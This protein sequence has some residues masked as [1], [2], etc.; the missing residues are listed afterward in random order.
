MS[1]SITPLASASTSW[2]SV[3]D[4]VTA[5]GYRAHKEH[6]LFLQAL[7]IYR[8]CP[9]CLAFLTAAREGMGQGNRE[10]LQ[11]YRMQTGSTWRGQVC[12]SL[13]QTLRDVKEPPDIT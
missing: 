9:M 7:N 6:L 4:N 1:E 2:V 10:P 3:T 8:V 5:D 12:M 13:R 11:R